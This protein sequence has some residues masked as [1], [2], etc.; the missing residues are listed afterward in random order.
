M[1]TVILIGRLTK[2]VELRF[3]ADTGTPVAN[4]TLA[5]DRHYTKK[6]GSKETDF[7]P[8]QLMGKIAETSA[9]YIG[10]GSLVSI[11]GNLRVDKY[12]KDGEYRTFTK[13]FGRNIKFLDTKKSDTNSNETFVPSFDPNEFQAI[14]TDDDIPF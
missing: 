11:E 6:D 4:F 14:E 9:N 5:V 10:K 8:I 7:I 12:E 13:V 1:N 3:I 2:D